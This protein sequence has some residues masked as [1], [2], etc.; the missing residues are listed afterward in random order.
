QA[1]E[2]LASPGLIRSSGIQGIKLL[3]LPMDSQG[4]VHEALE[5]ACRHHRLAALYCTPTLQ[6]PSTAAQSAA[7]REA[8]AEVCR[9]HNLLILEDE[10]HAVLMARRPAPLAQF[11]PERTVLISSPSKAVLGRALVR[12]GV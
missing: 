10:T 6:N 8:I 7:R 2:H 4:L 12:E 5:E 3:G 1:T 11:A 9:R